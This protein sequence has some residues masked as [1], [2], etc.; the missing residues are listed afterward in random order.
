VA[1]AQSR[2]VQRIRR[3]RLQMRPLGWAFIA[4]VV[5]S[6][7]QGRPAPGLAGTRLG[8]TAALAVCVL[9]AMAGL[10]PRWAERGDAAQALVIG[11][12]GG[13][14]VALAALQPHGATGLAA[15]RGGG[16]A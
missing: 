10:S 1:A 7:E 12:L 3:Q 4:A 8:I 9:A 15:G 13:G 14:G 11:L 2:A 16:I 5:I 6:A